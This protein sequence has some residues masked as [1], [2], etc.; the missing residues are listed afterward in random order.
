M[1]LSG[2]LGV[3]C[4]GAPQVKTTPE[5]H[6]QALAHG[7][8]LFVPLAVSQELGDERTGI[9]LSDETRAKASD[10]ACKQVAESVTAPAIV[11]LDPERAASVP[12]F[13]QIQLLFAR[14]QPI[15]PDVW[16][17]LRAAS[18]ARHVLLFR[19]EAVSSS[20]EVS[21]EKR[22]AL[23][24]VAG[25]A[26]GGMVSAILVAGTPA[27]ETKNETEVTYTLSG[28]LV[29]MQ[30]SKLLKVG[31]CSGSDS[32][33]VKHNLGFAEPPPVAPILEKIMVKLGEALLD[34]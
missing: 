22:R 33:T 19:P 29:D 26:V 4:G 3:G 8:V 21:R 30:S 15:P 32:R 7:R 20:R 16:Q 23:P 5:F 2:V 12:A 25:L 31:V 6:P 34:D 13:G 27:T 18:G 10:A 11:C 28:S 1:V 14:D 17:A 24:V 9:V